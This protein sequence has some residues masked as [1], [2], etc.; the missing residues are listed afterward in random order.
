[1]RPGVVSP[2]RTV[3]R[4]SVHSLGLAQAV[5][6]KTDD[7][8]GRRASINGSNPNVIAEYE[9]PILLLHV[10]TIV[11]FCTRSRSSSTRPRTRDVLHAPAHHL[12]TMRRR[13][14]AE[15]QFAHIRE[16]RV[17]YL[18]LHGILGVALS[19]LGSLH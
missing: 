9:P 18:F 3:A 14:S 15:Q 1:M 8:Q 17:R 4:T 2:P 16:H 7:W 12:E 13:I 6:V 11:T 10:L 5:E 19:L